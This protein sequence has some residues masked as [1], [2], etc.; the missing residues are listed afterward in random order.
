VVPE[1]I[2]HPH[3]WLLEIWRGLGGGTENPKFLK[4]SMKWNFW[5][6]GGSKSRNYLWGGGEW[7]FSGTTISNSE[8]PMLFYFQ[9]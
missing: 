3:G 8:C 1:N 9:A 7:V 6:G 5:R 4:E 2:H